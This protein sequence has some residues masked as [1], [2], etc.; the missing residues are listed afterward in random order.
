MLYQWLLAFSSIVVVLI[1]KIN[2]NKP[3]DPRRE[4]LEAILKSECP[5]AEKLAA[6]QRYFESTSIRIQA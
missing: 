3:S 1:T 2:M 6:V 4:D 5:T